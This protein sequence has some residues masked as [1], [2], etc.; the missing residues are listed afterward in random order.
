[1][2][3]MKPRRLSWPAAQAKGSGKAMER[4]DWITDKPGTEIVA[5]KSPLDTRLFDVTL[6]QT[7]M[8][9]EGMGTKDLSYSEWLQ[10][11]SYLDRVSKAFRWWVGDWLNYAE[12]RRDLSERMDQAVGMFELSDNTLQMY[13]SVAKRVPYSR[14]REELSWSMHNAVSSLSPCEQKHWLDVATPDGGDKIPIS[15]RELKSLISTEKARTMERPLEETYRCIVA[16]I[17]WETMAMDEIRLLN[18]HRLAANDGSHLYMVLSQRSINIGLELVKQWH[19]RFETMLC[20]VGEPLPR[21]MGWAQ[22]VR[23][24]LFASKDKLGIVTSGLPAGLTSNL[25]EPTVADFLGVI[26]KASPGPR[27]LVTKDK[28]SSSLKNY[29]FWLL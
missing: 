4:E 19:F 15:V 17:P 2:T 20:C 12:S 3:S 24:C 22:N 25:F 9:L 16:D 27:I 13:A 7:G 5:K 14:R 10:I 18:L 8:S 29:D 21:G 6:T 11:G 1:M 28:P 23:Y 26:E